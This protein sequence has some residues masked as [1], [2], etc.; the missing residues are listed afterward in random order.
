MKWWGWFSGQ[1]TYGRAVLPNK[2]LFWKMKRLQP[3]AEVTTIRSTC[4]SSEAVLQKRVLIGMCVCV[5]LLRKFF[6]LVSLVLREANL[7]NFF[8]FLMDVWSR[9]VVSP[10]RCEQGSSPWSVLTQKWLLLTIPFHCVPKYLHISGRGNCLIILRET[11]QT[12]KRKGQE[13]P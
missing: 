7:E 6:Y 12:N 2:S 3:L 4:E 13:N 5:H 8:F 9:L 1:I 11:L 10:V